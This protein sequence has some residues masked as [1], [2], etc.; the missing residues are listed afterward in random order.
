MQICCSTCSVILNLMATQYKCSVVH[1][2]TQQHIPP[3][4]TRTVKSSLFT[5]AH[6][7]PLSLAARLH[8]CHTSHSCHI[9]NGWIFSGQMSVYTYLIYIPNPQ[10][11]T[12]IQSVRL[13]YLFK[14]IFI[15]CIFEG[16]TIKQFETLSKISKCLQNDNSEMNYC[17]KLCFFPQVL[18]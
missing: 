13:N 9:N 6:S 4:L 5:H 14:Y 12:C 10:T 2:L 1:M 3:P 16:K 8:K 18:F 11:H 15:K 17:Q 7:N